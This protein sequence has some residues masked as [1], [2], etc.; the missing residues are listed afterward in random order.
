M[1]GRPP[2][3]TPIVRFAVSR[4]HESR[5]RSTAGAVGELRCYFVLHMKTPT[6]RGIGSGLAAGRL[7]PKACKADSG[8]RFLHSVVLRFVVRWIRCNIDVIAS[9]HTARGGTESVVYLV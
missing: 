3:G 8:G 6:P 9:R 4:K 5:I 2:V 7:G 1:F